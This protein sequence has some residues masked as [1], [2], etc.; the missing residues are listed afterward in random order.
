[1][2][3]AT[4]LTQYDEETGKFDLFLRWEYTLPENYILC[5]GR[6]IDP[7]NEVFEI[8]GKDQNG[9]EILVGYAAKPTHVVYEGEILPWPQFKNGTR[10]YSL[11]RAKAVS[12]QQLAEMDEYGYGD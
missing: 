7:E 4:R 2:I 6:P 5:N 9:T 3:A 1:M 10:C 12:E 8:R 11:K